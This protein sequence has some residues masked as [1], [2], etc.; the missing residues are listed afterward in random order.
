VHIIGSYVTESKAGRI[1]AAWTALLDERTAVC[2]IA[3]LDG[4]DLVIWEAE[5]IVKDPAHASPATPERFVTVG[6]PS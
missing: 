2:Q 1:A 3:G 6:Q 4:P 5:A